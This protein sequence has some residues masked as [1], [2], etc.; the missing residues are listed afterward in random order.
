M[1]DNQTLTTHMLRVAVPSLLF[2]IGYSTGPIIGGALSSVN[3]RWIFTINLPI[4]LLG[5]ILAFVTVRN[6]HNGSIPDA[7]N[8]LPEWPTYTPTSRLSALAFQLSR[9]DRVGA[10]LFISGAIVF[11]I[12]LSWGSTESWNEAKVIA[13]ITIRGILV[14]ACIVWEPYLGQY[15]VRSGPD[16]KTPILKARADGMTEDLKIP[17]RPIAHTSRMIPLWIFKNHQIPVVFFGAFTSRMVI[18]SGLYFLAVRWNTVAGFQNTKT[19]IRLVYLTPGIGGGVWP[20]FPI[21]LGQVVQAVGAGLLANAISEN[22]HG[23]INGFLA[24]CGAGIGFSMGTLEMQ[25]R[26]LLPKERSSPLTTMHLFFRT[27]GGTIGLAQLSAVLQSKLRSYILGLVKSGSL[28]LQD[29]LTIAQSLVSEGGKQS[30]GPGIAQL[31]VNLQQIVCDAYNY[32]VKWSFYSLL[33][34]CALSALAVFLLGN[35]VDT[36]RAERERK[37][38]EK[39]KKE[40]LIT[41]QRW[42]YQGT[43]RG[44]RWRCTDDGD[45]KKKKKKPVGYGPRYRGSFMYLVY[46]IELLLGTRRRPPKK[47]N[48]GQ[49]LTTPAAANTEG[50]PSSAV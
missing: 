19:G 20:R 33:P 18:L 39:E 31:P 11:L 21:M 16:G 3:F 49:P 30:S 14:V 26:F 1:A 43:D 17:P 50:N 13:C 7:H 10:F 23:Q 25:P 12:G 6:D 4:I 40:L 44:S 48:T 41:C 35:I 45:S 29:A 47:A 32:G 28:S 2:T 15:D 37:E 8:N 42:R 34:W 46:G 27:A 38:K 9:I 24:M 36:D 22:N 5:F